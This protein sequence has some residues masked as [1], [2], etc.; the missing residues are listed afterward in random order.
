L[1]AQAIDWGGWREV[2]SAARPERLAHLARQGF[3]SMAPAEA[4]AALG[5]VMRS[6]VVQVGVSPLDVNTWRASNAGNSTCRFTMELADDLSDTAPE[7]DASAPLS[8]REALQEALP[9]LARRQVLEICIQRHLARVLRMP[10]AKFDVRKSFKSL[11]L[12]SLTSLELRNYLEVDAQLKLPAALVYNHATIA[13]LATE[14]AGQLGGSLDAPT[15][16]NP[17]PLQPAAASNDD[18]LAALLGAL[19][20]LP[21]EEAMRLLATDASPGG[22]R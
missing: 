3:G 11:G 16:P 5:E 18:E 21:A 20:E 22:K 7:V 10:S 6:D 8:L 13:S 12:D 17:E 9:G 4:L 15:T 2:G 14:L 1:P 19:Q